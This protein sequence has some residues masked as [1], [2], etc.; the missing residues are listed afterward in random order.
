MVPPLPRS[1]LR[2]HCGEYRA[3][4]RERIRQ[5]LVHI[6][7]ER[8]VVGMDR[9]V[10]QL[11]DVEPERVI[12]DDALFERLAEARL[13]RGTRSVVRLFKKGFDRFPAE[14]E[15]NLESL[16]GGVADDCVLRERERLVE[17]TEHRLEV[18]T[19]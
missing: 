7:G 8:L 9:I 5:A 17:P 19:Q 4:A 18:P 12:L 3:E 13:R 16:D 1:L 10:A 14:L 6:V 11:R 2:R 15:G